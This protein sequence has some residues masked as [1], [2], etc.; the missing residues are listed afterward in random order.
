MP[1]AMQLELRRGYAAAVSFM[2]YQMG[3]ILTRL[4]DLPNNASERT[5]IIFTSDHGFSIGDHGGWGK[6]SLWE[7]DARVPL[8]I[9]VPPR[10]LQQ[11]AKHAQLFAL[12]SAMLQKEQNHDYSGTKRETLL[13]TA[14]ILQRGQRTAAFVELI[15]LFPTISDLAGLELGE[16]LSDQSR[17]VS[18]SFLYLF[19]KPWPATKLQLRDEP[20]LDGVSLVPL[21][22]T[23]G[24]FRTASRSK[25]SRQ[26]EEEKLRRSMGK[27]HAITQFPRCPVR[28]NRIGER[29]T[30]VQEPWR[31]CG[32]G[33]FECQGRIGDWSFNHDLALMGY[34]LRTD[35]WRYTAWLRVIKG[36]NNCIKS[37]IFPTSAVS[38]SCEAG[39]FLNWTYPPYATELYR[40]PNDHVM[41][42][43][44]N[45]GS[46]IE[47]I[48]REEGGA[49]DVDENVNIAHLYKN[50]SRSLFD[51]LK[52]TERHTEAM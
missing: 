20:K 52:S 9:K 41:N 17:N 50:I 18:K 39:A 11:R 4:K 14:S 13:M 16:A 46:T 3:R 28:Y 32:A 26:S 22:L 51:V 31:T 37:D 7:P 24:N 44:T 43:N 47:D 48:L 25:E 8:I 15:D 35:G 5:V 12:P 42:S 21:F 1:K 2:D 49:F 27:K 34:S 45:R 29:K 38:L 6:R 30:L 40:H 10:I 23:Q 19:P 36:G 33:G